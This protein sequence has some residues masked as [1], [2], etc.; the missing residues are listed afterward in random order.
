VSSTGVDTSVVLFSIPRVHVER[1]TIADNLGSG[2]V[3]NASNSTSIG[4]LMRNAIHRNSNYGI[5]VATNASPNSSALVTL[6]ENAVTGNAI[7]IKADGPRT[8][9]YVGSNHLANFGT[10]FVQANGAIFYSYHNNVGAFT[11]VGTISTATGL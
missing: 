3:L 6:S 4:S 1:S 5:H 8:V 7:G 9:A 2:F 10:D 11:Q